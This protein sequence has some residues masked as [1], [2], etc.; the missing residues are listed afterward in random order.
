MSAL[1]PRPPS[2]LLRAELLNSFEFVLKQI[3]R[4]AREHDDTICAALIAD[5][6]QQLCF[7]LRRIADQQGITPGVHPAYR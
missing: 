2:Q 1:K 7:M 5:D 6:K 3:G 4:I